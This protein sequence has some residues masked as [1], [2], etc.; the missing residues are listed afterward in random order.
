MDRYSRSI[1]PIPLHPIPLKLSSLLKM[2]NLQV[3]LS[4]EEQ[5]ATSPRVQVKL[6]LMAPNVIEKEEICDWIMNGT[7]SL[8]RN[9]KAQPT[10]MQAMPIH[11]AKEN[12]I[13]P[14]PLALLLRCSHHCPDIYGPFSPNHYNIISFTLKK[15]P[16]IFNNV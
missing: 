8:Q 13:E 15:K 9:G 11:F 4:L 10:S 12:R 14:G 1:Q 3:L 2:H 16:F 7:Y 6:Q 5:L